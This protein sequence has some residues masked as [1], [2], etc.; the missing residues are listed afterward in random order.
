MQEP[1]KYLP[2]IANK[3]RP[4]D[5]Y[6]LKNRMVWAAI[7][8]KHE[9]GQH[10]DL[11]TV[12]LELK[13]VIEIEKL[14]GHEWL[15]KLETFAPS[16]AAIELYAEIIITLGKRRKLL[17][18]CSKMEA[19]IYE[20]DDAGISLEIDSISSSGKS[21]RVG[22]CSGKLA[23]DL[24]VDDLQRR[25]DLNGQLSGIDTGFWEMNRLTD[26]IQYG[27]QTII[28]A[29]PSM[30]KTAI[31][32]N[33]FQNAVFKLGIPSLFISLEMSTAALMKRLLSSYMTIPMGDIRRGSYSEGDFG[34]FSTFKAICDKAPMHIADAVSGSSIGDIASIV[35]DYTRRHG[36]RLVVIDYLQKI[37][38]ADKHEKKT[39][40]V[41]DISGRLK[42]LAVDTGAAF[43]TLAQL[44]RESE[45]DKGRM[46]RLTDLADSSQIE[47][48]GDTIMLIHRDRADK[49]GDTKIIVAKQRDGEVGMVNLIFNGMFC[50]FE[51]KPIER[52][53]NQNDD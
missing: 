38:S 23:G 34:K 30:G 2:L 18:S 1:R 41:G 37:K 53:Q 21:S 3:I 46:P 40:E 33:I 36:V 4:D 12:M 31:G 19:M 47:R 14:G 16:P 17:Q 8:A 43:L 25:F 27:E 39:Y 50:K 44:N 32:L 45:K 7:K 15:S 26:G 20:G 13:S 42:G 5:F 11:I 29:R 49:T 51:N 9:S 48:D 52:N 6:D 10:I 35:R 28:G 22:I 24:M